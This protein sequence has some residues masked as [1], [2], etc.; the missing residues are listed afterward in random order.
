MLH[1]VIDADAEILRH[2][3]ESG[4]AQEIGVGGSVHLVEAH[5]VEPRIQHSPPETGEAVVHRPHIQGAFILGM[6][7]HHH[8][9]SQLLYHPGVIGRPPGAQGAVCH[10]QHHGVVGG[11]GLI[12]FQRLC[13]RCVADVIERSRDAEFLLQQLA[14][15]PDRMGVLGLAVV[16]EGDVLPLQGAEALRKRLIVGRRDL[17]QG[18]HHRDGHAPVRPVAHAAIRAGCGGHDPDEKTNRQGDRQESRDPFSFHGCLPSFEFRNHR[19]K[20][21]LP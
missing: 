13:A 21:V 20:A 9:R 14:H 17:P 18:I 19:R 2:R 12:V 15:G 11:Q 3:D 7:Q 10:T 6:G 16:S 5:A 1:L 8:G 4:I